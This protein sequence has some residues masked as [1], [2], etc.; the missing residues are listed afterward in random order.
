MNVK[1]DKEKFNPYNTKGTVVF[2]RVRNFFLGKNTPGL[3]TRISC[4]ISI[5]YFFYIFLYALTILLAFKFGKNL[6]QG[7]HWKKLFEA[8]GAKYG[9]TNIDL[10]F[11]LY[12]V[13]LIVF[14]VI[15]FLATMFVWRRRLKGY[16]PVI[17]SAIICTFASFAFLGVNYVEAETGWWEFAFGGTVIVLF[18][19]DFFARRKQLA[20]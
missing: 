5:L 6:P 12:L 11:T 16:L 7:D 9:I 18:T 10:S 14:S 1:I 4:N 3:F 15:S 17:A 19:V 8:I 20:N 13:S 2:S